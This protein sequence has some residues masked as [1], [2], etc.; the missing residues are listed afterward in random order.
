MR[1]CY[2]VYPSAAKSAV[3]E[4]QMF[5]H[6]FPA[7][8]FFRRVTSIASPTFRSPSL[9]DG[10]FTTFPSKN[11]VV[12]PPP[13]RFIASTA[14]SESRYSANSCK[15]RSEEHTSE[16]QSLAYLVCRLLLERYRHHRHLHSFPTRRSSDLAAGFFRRV[17]SIAS[18]T[19]RS[20]SLSDGVFTTFPSKNIV[21]DPPPSRFIASTA[22]S[23]S[24]YSANSCKL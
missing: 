15:L 10:V 16:L 24:R 5:F 23:E 4:Q 1:L 9:S 22:P 8:G 11:I 6:F 21:V 13:S 19:F 14:P 17:T 3:N 12:D 20:P 2:L 18:P 7:A